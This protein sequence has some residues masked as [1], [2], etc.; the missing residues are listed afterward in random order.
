MIT[1]KKSNELPVLDSD[2]LRIITSVSS[3][4]AGFLRLRSKSKK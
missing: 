3:S 4:K 2:L 1:K